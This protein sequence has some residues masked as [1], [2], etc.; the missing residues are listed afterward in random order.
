MS[1]QT[2]DPRASAP[3]PAAGADG[4]DTLYGDLT[5]TAL[6]GAAAVM[7]A[8]VARLAEKSRATRLLDLG[9]G[10]GDHARDAAARLAATE[11]G[12]R[13][14][15]LDISPAN[16]ALARRLG[17][18]GGRIDFVAAD[19]LTRRLDPFDM[20]FS[21]GVLHLI[22]GDDQALAAKLAVDTRPG[23]LVLTAMPYECPANTLLIA[24]R[25]LLRGVRAA[26]GGAWLDRLILGL[27]A[28][29]HPDLDPSIARERLPYMYITPERQDGPAFRR[30]MARAGFELVETA[31]W[32]SPSRAKLRHR[33]TVWRRTQ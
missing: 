14:T 29:L 28:R 8:H 1:S 12:V 23:G 2:P 19:Y 10:V 20:I 16:I 18:G 31:P 11:S 4:D 5:L 15:A 3:V 6:P 7:G 25:R 30:A 33:L 32:P 24:L 26:P 22:P 21:E 17:D 13:I 27:A 9:C